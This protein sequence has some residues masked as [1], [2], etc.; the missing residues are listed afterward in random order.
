MFI[1][2]EWLLD[3]KIYKSNNWNANFDDLPFDDDESLIARRKLYRIND[4]IVVSL[5]N[6][7][8]VYI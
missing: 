5:I 8:S 7:S 6:G 1:S 2:I 3:K 4:I